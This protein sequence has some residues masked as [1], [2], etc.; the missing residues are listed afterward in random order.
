[1][2]HFSVQ[3][4]LRNFFKHAF[5][6]QKLVKLLSLLSVNKYIVFLVFLNK[7][8]TVIFCYLF[9]SALLI[10]VNFPFICVLSFFAF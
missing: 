9:S 1:M 6:V 3:T 4:K 8:S 2:S 7:G 10:S 5:Y